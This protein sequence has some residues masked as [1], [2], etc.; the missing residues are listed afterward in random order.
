MEKNDVNASLI[1]L[2]GFPR[3]M[4]ISTADI[5]GGA[6]KV[7]WD[8]FH[9]YNDFELH[10]ILLVGYKF[11]DN[12]YVILLPNTKYHSRW[13]R[14]W[15]KIGKLISPFNS[16]VNTFKKINHIVQI[17]SE[18]RRYCDIQRGHEDFNFPGTAHLLELLPEPPDIIHCHNLHGGYFDLRMLPS[19]SKN[20]PTILTLHDAWLLSGHCAYSLDCERW[21]TGC[22]KCPDLTLYPSIRR[23]ATS[24]NWNRKRKIFSRSRLYVTTPSTWLMRKVK[25]SIMAEAIIESRVIHYGVNLKI[26]YPSDMQEARVALGI[27]EDAKVLLFVGHKTRTNIWKD[28]QTLETAV[29]LVSNKLQD[30][31]ILLLCLGEKRKS[32]RI[33]RAEIWFIDYQKDSTI[34]AQYYRA[35]NI[36]IHAANA[37]NFPCTILEALACGV[38]V[39]ATAVGGIPE[40]VRGLKIDNFRFRTTDLNKY[41]LDKAT[42]VLVQSKDSKEMANVIELLLNNEVVLHQLSANAA[43]DAQQRFDLKQQVKRYLEWYKE[44]KE[45]T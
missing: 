26:F 21:K 16:K 6:E 10:S 3:V 34:V 35:A 5:A 39:V 20:V 31:H 27:P 7:A 23:D 13:T 17:L 2:N 44:I 43:Q 1:R 24:Y 29:H 36:Y 4:Q 12:P 38:P 30:E 37:D 22:G 42:G 19:F 40:Q 11:S 28:Y 9:A 45:Y 14:F 8:L 18:P 41:S 32:E 25:Q 33:G 15:I